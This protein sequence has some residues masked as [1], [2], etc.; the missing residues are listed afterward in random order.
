MKLLSKSVLLPIFSVGLA[1]PAHAE[2]LRLSLDESIQAAEDYSPALKAARFD[3]DSAAAHESAVKVGLLPHIGLDGRYSYAAQVLPPITLPPSFASTFGINQ[4]DFG[5]HNNYSVGVSANWDIIGGVSTWRQWQVATEARKAA[6]AQLDDAEQNLR[7]K[8]RLAYF[9]TRLDETQVR[10]YA[11]ALKLAQ[12]QAHDL[13]LRLKA[14]TSSK[15]DWLTASNDELDRKAS[16]RL[17]QVDLAGALRDLF[18]LTG[19]HQAADVSIPVDGQDGRDLPAKVDE[20]TV[21]VRLDDTA[22]LLAEL[23]PAES[24]GFQPQNIAKLRAL[25]AQV[26]EAR[27]M[28]AAAWA[29]H[30]P[31]GTVG[32]RWSY[33][34]PEPPLPQAVDQQTTSAN[35]NLPLFSFG[36]VSDQVR[37]QQAQADAAAAQAGDA[38]TLTKTDWLKSHDRLSGLRAQRVLQVQED[39][40]TSELRQMVYRSYKIGGSTYLEVQSTTLESLQAGLALAQTETQMLIELANLSALTEADR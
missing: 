30:L 27:R 12:S 15:I 39:K 1:L 3:V 16:Y 36:Q 28:T 22:A 21:S 6:E 9:Q 37:S 7:L 13:S 38:V 23:E 25:W 33:D 11:D 40:Q 4:L 31:S 24:A 18:A 17:A 14:G 10:L 35:F 34:Y 2:M 32:F 5:F 8:V 20:P 19:Q 26:E 29:G